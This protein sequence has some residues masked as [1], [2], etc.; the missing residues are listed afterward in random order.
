MLEMRRYKNDE[1]ADRR[2]VLNGLGRFDDV[3][4]EV[5]IAL[6]EDGTEY[7]AEGDRKAIAVAGSWPA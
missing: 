3:P 4:E 5:V 1:R 2:R 7:A 6:S